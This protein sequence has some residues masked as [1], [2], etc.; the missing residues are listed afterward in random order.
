MYLLAILTS[1][2]VPLPHPK[3]A[4][5]LGLSAGLMFAQSGK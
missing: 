5:R 3:A 1:G 2:S 4:I